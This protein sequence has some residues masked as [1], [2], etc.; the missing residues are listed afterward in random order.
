MND[1]RPDA[2]PDQATT[3]AAAEFRA[4]FLTSATWLEL[5]ADAVNGLNIFP[6]PDGD[7]GLNMALTLRAAADE[8]ATRGDDDV[9][10][11]FNGLAHGALMG[12]R[13]NSGVILAQYLRGMMRASTSDR[14]IDGEALARLLTAGAE[15]AYDAVAQP[16][17]GTILTVA[18]C[19]AEAARAAAAEAAAI[20]AVL[21]A[22][23]AA[24]QAAV[25][26]T[27]DQLP[28]LRQAGV[29]DAGGEGFRVWLEGLL[30]HLRGES[31]VG[32]APRI[33]KHADLSAL[34]HTAD[35]DGY[36]TEVLFRPQSV[37]LAA[38]R[39]RVETLGTSALVVGD[40]DL[41]KIHVHTPRPGGAL[42]LATEL[43]EIVR[44]KVDN[45]RLQF[46]AFASAALPVN[47]VPGTSVVAVALGS[48]F[49]EIFAS[50][51]ALV[52][53]GGQSMN[54]AVSEIVAAIQRA[55]REHVVVL[56][57]NP[58]VAMAAEQAA[59]SVASR[60]ATILPTR[61]MCQGI[62]AALALSPDGDFDANLASAVRAADRCV[63]IELTRAARET[64]I[65]GRL[66]SMGAWLAIVD[67]EL[68]AGP[69]AVAELVGKV[70]DGLPPGPFD[71]ATIYD[72]TGGLDAEIEEIRDLIA[73][74]LGVPVERVRGG[75]PHYPYIISLE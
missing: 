39:E 36:C 53:A 10:A 45:M 32:H 38:L 75:Q 14:A 7:T 42:D 52:V 50:L 48:G 73:S 8:A 66:V 69:E 37:E 61:T 33:K 57:N 24:A 72:G 20:T 4:A 12:A 60:S 1:V 63:T 18:R 51:D 11:L 28:V 30:L 49:Q 15:A 21:D 70:L 41:V 43:G 71:I 62:A 40:G 56:P 59:Q 54:P 23:H 27:P 44:V 55:P 16:V 2:H 74:R 46:E 3:I 34:Q 35:M 29:V 58:N 17:E 5:N 31:I 22:A 67:G 64:E 9:R 47:P 26:R 6:V 25:D 68:I 19:A 13:G 65:A